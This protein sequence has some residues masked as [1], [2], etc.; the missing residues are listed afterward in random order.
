M[1]E[2]THI[3]SHD[4]YITEDEDMLIDFQQGRAR[5]DIHIIDV[6]PYNGESIVA[7][8][9]AEVYPYVD[10]I[11][12]TEAR[13]T[14]SGVVKDELFVKL[15]AAVFAPYMDKIRVCI[16]DEFDKGAVPPEWLASRAQCSWMLDNKASWYRESVQRNACA[17]YLATRA[18]E[19]R[20]TL[21]ICS[22]VDEIPN[23]PVIAR[24]LTALYET[25]C[26]NQSPVHLEMA[27]F[28]YSWDW[29][30]P[31]KWYHAFVSAGECLERYTLDDMRVVVP[32]THILQDGGWHCSYFMDVGELKRKL[33]SFAHRECD[34]T[35]TRDEAHVRECIQTGK[36]L[37]GR[38]EKENCV[39]RSLEMDMPLH[40]KDVVT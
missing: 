39:R 28:Y 6:F 7:L 5:E 31:Y 24:N 15:N 33:Q 13:E 8:R 23:M 22:D 11:V 16:V 26:G 30:K 38:G 34:T 27:M 35:A 36:D 32:K 4:S 20:K 21:V 18:R 1:E 40:W 9:L 25:S 17:G 12:V 2:P 37:F 14:H 3:S 19:L 29:M 10:E